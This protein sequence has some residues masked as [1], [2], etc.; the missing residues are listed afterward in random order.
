[1]TIM[2]KGSKWYIGTLKGKGN[3]FYNIYKNPDHYKFKQFMAD[4]TQNPESD[5]EQIQL[6]RET[7]PLAMWM[8]EY[9]NV[10]MEELDSFFPSAL[11]DRIIG[12]FQQHE[13]PIPNPA[14]SYYLGVDPAGEG[15]DS[16]VYCILMKSPL[17]QMN[18]VKFIEAKKQNLNTID[19]NIRLLHSLWNFKK[20][21]IDITGGRNI[22]EFLMRDGIPA[23]G[24]KFTL[25]S[26]QDVFHYLKQMMQAEGFSMYKNDECIKQLLDMRYEPIK[27]G[28]NQNIKIFSG[29]SRDHKQPGGDDYPTAMALAV[30]ATKIP[31]QPVIFGIG[32][33][34]FQRNE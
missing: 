7:M 28:E 3:H 1:M 19:T 29:Q 16:T 30:W 11:V 25:Q 26:K 6:D 20:I 14:Y 10:P 17:G 13:A 24:V 18:V 27:I 32:K 4:Y 21:M 22:H 2:T 8:Q 15:M 33:T 9:L 12:K 5:K 34:I 23:D 31:E